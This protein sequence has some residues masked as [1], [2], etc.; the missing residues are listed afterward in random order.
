MNEN[1]GLVY[2]SYRVSLFSIIKTPAKSAQYLDIITTA[3][4]LYLK[5]IYLRISTT[6]FG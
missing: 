4:G 6:P 5:S 2:F 3:L 1:I